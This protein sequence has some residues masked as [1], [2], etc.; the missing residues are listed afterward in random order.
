MESE[1]WEKE[2]DKKGENYL[3]RIW[4]TNSLLFCL[5]TNAKYLYCKVRFTVYSLTVVNVEISEL[6]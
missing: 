5:N 6:E 1:N 2:E 3:S 4:F